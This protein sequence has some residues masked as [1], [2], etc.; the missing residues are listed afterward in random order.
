[1]PLLHKE[2]GKLGHYRRSLAKKPSA[3]HIAAHFLESTVTPRGSVIALSLTASGVPELLTPLEIT[4]SKIETGIVVLSGCSSGSGEALPASGLMGLTRAWLAA[5]A[6]AVVASH[7]PTQD[8]SGILFASFYRHL[9]NTPE[10]GPAVALRRAQDD[11][12][13]A[14]GWRADPQYWATYFVV[15]DQ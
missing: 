9:C 12:L 10:A 11:M 1:M 14:G 7:W 4:R 5:G 8:D 2:K 15:G 13:R 6:R 3:I